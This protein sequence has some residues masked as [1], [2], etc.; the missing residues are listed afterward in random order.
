MGALLTAA[1][2]I[3]CPHG[4][5]ASVIPAQAQVTLGGDAVLTAADTFIIGGCPFMIALVPSPCITVQWA[6]TD[7]ATSAGAPTLSSDSAGLCIAATGAVQGAVL[8]ADPG[9][10]QV[11]SL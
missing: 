2:S 1:A 4:G 9:Q 11:T 6:V 7:T 8:I 5:Q 10:A 3:M